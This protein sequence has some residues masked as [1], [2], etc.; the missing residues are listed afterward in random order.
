[1]PLTELNSIEYALLAERLSAQTEAY[2]KFAQAFVRIL[3][4]INNNGDKIK[5]LQTQEG[6]SFRELLQSIVKVASDLRDCEETSK[7]RDAGTSLSLKQ[8][9][10]SG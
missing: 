9:S 6:Q 8:S 7:D 2:E 5:D 3:E 4:L 10:H 1:M